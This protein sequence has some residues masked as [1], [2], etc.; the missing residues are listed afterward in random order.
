[1]CVCV[2]EFVNLCVCVCVRMRARARVCVCVCMC[3]CVRVCVLYLR[4]CVCVCVCVCVVCLCLCLCVCVC[5]CVC[6]FVFSWW[7]MPADARRVLHDV[8]YCVCRGGANAAAVSEVRRERDDQRGGWQHRWKR[9]LH[10]RCVLASRVL[11]V[12]LRRWLH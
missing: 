3:V 6:V 12:T 10:L 9:R 7:H 1:V 4:V 11:R 8:S 5:V 2:C